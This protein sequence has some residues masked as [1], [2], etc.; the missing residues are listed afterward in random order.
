[1]ARKRTTTGKFYYRDGAGR[2]HPTDIKPRGSL[3][4]VS[5]SRKGL[6]VQTWPRMITE[7]LTAKQFAKLGKPATI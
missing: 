3:V 4:L 6:K 5:T 1:M 2:W 7:V